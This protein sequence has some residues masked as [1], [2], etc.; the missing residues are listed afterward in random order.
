MSK[1]N[2][3]LLILLV[4]ALAFMVFSSLPK[5]YGQSEL[6]QIRGGACK[7]VCKKNYDCDG[8]KACPGNCTGADNGALC[9]KALDGTPSG[10]V[11]GCGDPVEGG[12]G[13]NPGG[14]T[15][16]DAD[17]CKCNGGACQNKHTS[18]TC[19]YY[20]SCSTD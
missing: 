7:K 6:E 3:F 2:C 5:T 19:N 8:K 18:T 20:S 11:W 17:Q 10:D 12:G 4:F 14:D 16:H 1:R 13:C 9:G 15:S